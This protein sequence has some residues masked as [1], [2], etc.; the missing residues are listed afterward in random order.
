MPEIDAWEEHLSPE[1]RAVWPILEK[2][3]RGIDGCLMGGTALAVHLR[4]RVSFD[5]DY[6]TVGSFSGDHLARKF[7]K[8]V[9][10]VEV[11]ARTADQMHARILGVQM[12]VFATPHRG[13]NPGHVKPIQS[14]IEVDGLK[15]ASLP[16]LVASKMDVILYRPKLRD[17]IDLHAIDTLGPYR[18]ED[19]LRFHLHRYGITPAHK[20]AAR[21]VDLLKD[22]GDLI[23]DSVFEDRREDVLQYLA[24]RAPDVERHLHQMRLETTSSSYPEP[25]DPPINLGLTEEFDEAIRSIHASPPSAA[26]DSST[27]GHKGVRNG[28]PCIRPP[29]RKGR[30]RY[31]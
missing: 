22:P 24:K 6:M 16:D 28:K 31:K 15:V 25:F 23:I 29:H 9:E 12:Q 4:H 2:A 10:D 5:L 13:A 7:E 1:M 26:G 20:D 18:L 17:Y 11:Y 14:P 8:A 21:I 30:H 3:T 19:G 27:C